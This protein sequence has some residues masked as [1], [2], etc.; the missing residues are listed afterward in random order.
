MCST[1][2]EL[3]RSVHSTLYT[4][5]QTTNS[6]NKIFCF[7]NNNIFFKFLL[8]NTAPPKLVVG[9][10]AF[11]TWSARNR[12]LTLSCRVECEPKCTISWLINNRTLNSDHRTSIAEIAQP[13][14]GELFA[15]TVSYL[16]INDVQQLQPDN[17]IMCRSES[18]TVGKSVQ[19]ISV[20]KTEGKFVFLIS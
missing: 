12:S 9:L 7:F 19:S 6:F 11:V 10:P 4:V 15:S 5:G 17:Q 8:I 13:A 20:F 14:E 3:Y 18:N 2:L 16:R 1:L